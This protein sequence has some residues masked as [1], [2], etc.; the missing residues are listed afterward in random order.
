VDEMFY[1]YEANDTVVLEFMINYTS[2][3]YY[4]VTVN[5][6]NDI[7]FT[8]Q[9]ELISVEVPIVS[10]EIETENI[11]DKTIPVSLNISLNMGEDGPQKVKFKVDHADGNVKY[12]NY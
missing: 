5:T 1:V 8:S 7:S 11:F 12:Y 10:M 6:S 2:I 3:G 9:S 4:D